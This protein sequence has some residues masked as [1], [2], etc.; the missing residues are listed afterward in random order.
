MTMTMTIDECKNIN[1]SLTFSESSR[2]N[3]VLHPCHTP[4]EIAVIK[5][6]DP[7]VGVSHPP[8]LPLLGVQCRQRLRYQ[9]QTQQFVLTTQTGTMMFRE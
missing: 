3:M 5:G 2:E 4:T 8:E 6:W 7:K 1:L 9:Y